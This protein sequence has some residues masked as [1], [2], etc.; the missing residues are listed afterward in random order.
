MRECNLMTDYQTVYQRI[1]SPLGPITLSAHDQGVLGVWF[2]RQT[3][4]PADL[5]RPS[6]DHAM[7][8][9]ARA[10]LADYFDGHFSGSGRSFSVP[11]AASGTPFQCLV[12]QALGTI[13]YGQTWSYQDLA[14]AI[15]RPTAARAVGMANGKNPLSILVPC[16]R[17]IGKG[18]QLTGYAGGIE[19]KV[20]LLNHEANIPHKTS[21]RFD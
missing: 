10:E 13:P 20:W 6:A 8:R 5:G 14:E 11:L 12:W 16:H 3:S 18:G 9:W 19:R 7:I 4:Q 1:D 2:T 17:V 15:G 21:V